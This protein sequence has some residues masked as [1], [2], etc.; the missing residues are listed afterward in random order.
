[1]RAAFRTAAVLGGLLS[2]ASASSVRADEIPAEYRESVAKGL[3]WMA[4]QQAKDGH[5]EAFGGNY[6]ITMTAMGGMS[7]L[8]EGSTLRE[9]KYKDNLRRATD[10]LM[11]KAQPNGHARQPSHPR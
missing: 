2:L 7:L 5:W 9:G 11:S 1:M 8:M 3:K 6:P 4:E 10:W